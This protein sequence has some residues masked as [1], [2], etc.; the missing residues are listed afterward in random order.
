MRLLFV[1]EVAHLP[2]KFG[3]VESNTHETA[4]ELTR[5]G[6]FVAVAAELR[7]SGFLALRTR[8]LGKLGIGARLHDRAMGYPAYR[9]WNVRDSMADLIA[10]IRPD[11]V[12]VQPPRQIA[13]AQALRQMG[14]PVMVYFHDVDYPSLGG[15]PASVPGII[16]LANS[17]FTAR[18]YQERYGISCDVVLP[19][20]RAERYRVAGPGSNVTLVN[21]HFS[22]GGELALSLAA[23]CPDI[24][25]SLQKSWSLPR[26]Q[27][28][29]ILKHIET[30]P[31]VTLKPPT[32]NM[33]EVY[34]Q[35]RIILMPSRLDEAWGRV[36]SEA[37][38]SGIP[39]IASRRG[40]LPEAVGPGGVLLDPDGPFEAWVD[41]VRKLWDD[42]AHY[43]ALSAAALA[44]AKRPEI[45]PGT[46]AGMLIAAAERAVLEQ[47]GQRMPS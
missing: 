38:L 7:P 10:V 24:P 20:F 47:R 42:E 25:F 8:L 33:K 1:S 30:H 23:A 45:D 46:Q 18:A 44:H 41:A 14:V 6:H 32:M 37:H 16:F 11:V 36:A 19:L 5:R 31:N 43:R 9:R 28:A 39:V 15:D 12:I 2:Q 4:L 22:K 34:R 29:A 27:E 21:P 40:G 3:G 13:V 26:E 17:Q 35:A